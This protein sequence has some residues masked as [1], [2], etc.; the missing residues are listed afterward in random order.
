MTRERSAY[1]PV[2]DE[3]ERGPEHDDARVARAAFERAS[4]AY[5]A[6]PLPWI[7]WA[8]VLPAAALATPRAYAVGREAGVVLAW[9]VA[10]LVGGA[11]EGASLL[12]ARRTIRGGP[13]GAW[14]MR[15]QGNLSLVAVAL[16]GLLVWL[17]G[18]R[19]LPGL[20]LLLLGH[21]F[22]A[23][24]GLSLPALRTTGVLYQ[25]GGVSALLPG[26]PALALFAAVTA[27]GN[28]W[29]AFGIARRARRPGQTLASRVEK[30]SGDS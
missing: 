21:S 24:G 13:L 7:A 20:W 17:D 18:A 3:E 19:A 29:V 14:A 16:S 15:V 11:V 8:L 9:S 28:L 5:L 10:I 12:L 2:F 30:A 26:A 1:D 22:F 4:R 23:L 6:S 25:L 27:A